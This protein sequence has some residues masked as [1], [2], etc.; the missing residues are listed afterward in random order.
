VLI[1]GRNCLKAI[2]KFR[3]LLDETQ[4]R[5]QFATHTRN[6]QELGI[7]EC[8]P[9]TEYFPFRAWIPYGDMMFLRETKEGLLLTVRVTPRSSRDEIV[10]THGDAL[11][12]IAKILPLRF[13]GKSLQPDHH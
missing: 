6:I 9:L 3:D 1:E 13:A 4:A 11:K 12:I 2:L 10:G 8:I 5:S 7:S